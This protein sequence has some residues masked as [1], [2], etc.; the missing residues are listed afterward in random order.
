[1]TACEVLSDFHERLR[2]RGIRLVIANLPGN[3]RDRLVRGWE[4]A[5]TD[6][7]LFLASVGAAVRDLGLS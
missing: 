1:L 6:K 5:A 2:E 4:A 7:G 3:V